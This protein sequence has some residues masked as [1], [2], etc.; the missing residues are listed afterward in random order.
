MTDSPRSKLS[1]TIKE[2]SA[3]ERM[4]VINENVDPWLQ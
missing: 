4:T 1:N 3:G 2:E